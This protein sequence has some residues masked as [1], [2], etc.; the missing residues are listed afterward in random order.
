MI[1]AMLSLDLQFVLK[2]PSGGVIAKFHYSAY[3][4]PVSHLKVFDSADLPELANDGVGDPIS[5]SIYFYLL[6]DFHY[7]ILNKVK[8]SL[9][10]VPESSPG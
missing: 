9:H 2:K 3:T 10:S 8:F 1:W 5:Q 7:A 4:A 6:A